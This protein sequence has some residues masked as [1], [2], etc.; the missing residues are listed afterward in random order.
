MNENKA[1]LIALMLGATYY[2]SGGGVYLVVIRK[3]SGR[4]VV[5]SDEVMAEFRTQAAFENGEDPLRQVNLY[6]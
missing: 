4:Y 6:E 5:I 2:N 1:R 3:P